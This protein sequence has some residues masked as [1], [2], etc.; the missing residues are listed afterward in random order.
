M[1]PADTFP[2]AANTTRGVEIN[3]TIPHTGTRRLPN[4]A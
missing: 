4:A 2:Y 3:H 1:T